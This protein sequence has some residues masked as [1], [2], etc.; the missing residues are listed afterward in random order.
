MH[1]GNAVGFVELAGHLRKQF[2]GC[3]ANRASQTGVV[4]N[5]FLNQTRQHTTAFALAAGHIGEVDV[6][7]VNPTVFHQRRNVGDDVFEALRIVTVLVKVH[8]QQNGVGAKLGGFHHA[9]G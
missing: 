4:K 7:L 2:I 1:D 5:T 3:H 8:R 9:H 6:H